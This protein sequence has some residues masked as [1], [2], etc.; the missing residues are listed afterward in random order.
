MKP[1]TKFYISQLTGVFT[2]MIPSVLGGI[3]LGGRIAAITGIDGTLAAAPTILI[4]TYGIYR[5]SSA[6]TGFVLEK[7]GLLPKFA[8][9]HYPKASSW[10][11]YLK[12]TGAL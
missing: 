7:V 8:W 12:R 2:V 11:G 10:G 9:R 4:C 3:L 5:S 6:L 1:N